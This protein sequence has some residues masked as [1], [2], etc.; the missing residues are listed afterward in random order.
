MR[1]NATLIAAGLLLLATLHAHAQTVTK[2]VSPQGYI[3][4]YEEASINWSEGV[5][6]ATGVGLQRRR[7][8]RIAPAR[9]SRRA[10]TPDWTRSRTCWMLID[11]VQIDAQYTGADYMMMQSEVL[12][13]SV[14]GF[15]RG[16]QILDERKIFIEG[17][18][19]VQVTVG[20]AMYGKN[21]LESPAVAP[22]ACDA[23]ACERPNAAADRPAR[24]QHTCPHD[25]HCRGQLYGAD[26]RRAG[27][28]SSLRWRPVS[29]KRMAR[30]STAWGTSISIWSS[31]KGLAS[32]H[33][34][35]GAARSDPRAG[36][37][38][39]VLRPI[40]VY[41][42]S[43]ATTDVVLSDADAA[44]LLTEDARTGFLKQLQSGLRGGLMLGCAKNRSWTGRVNSLCRKGLGVC[45]TTPP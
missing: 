10:A 18:E 15:M 38:P 8:N 41:R 22:V 9:T 35:M 23:R 28:K 36:S 3:E 17:Q 4:V 40:G 6:T 27:W 45:F 14:T 26:Y 32:Y 25:A 24:A 13:A 42:R 34:D 30:P 12:R 39:L 1:T 2:V 19:A 21:G 29:S 5:L 33:R 11:R 43:A 31:E 44:K 37:N 20:T 16:A 7:T